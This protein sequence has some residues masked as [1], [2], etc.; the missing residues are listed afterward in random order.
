MLFVKGGGEKLT[1]SF[2]ACITKLSTGL[3]K[4]TMTTIFIFTINFDS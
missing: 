1:S 2:K 4:L 3:V